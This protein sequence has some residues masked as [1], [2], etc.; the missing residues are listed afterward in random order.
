[1]EVKKRDRTEE[2]RKR[3]TKKRAA[4]K[5]KQVAAA[6]EGVESHADNKFTLIGKIKESPFYGKSSATNDEKVREILRGE[7]SVN[8]KKHIK[9]RPGQLIIFKYFTPIHKE[10]LEYYD[11]SPCTIFF[12][13]RTTSTGQK[14]VVG[15]NLHYFP[16]QIRYQVLN[17]IFEIYRPI[18]TKYFKGDD[19]EL[20]NISYKSLIEGV[21]KAKLDFGVRE[22]EVN[23][24]ADVTYIPPKYWQ[25]AVFTE[26]WFKKKTREAIM[27]YWNQFKSRL[28]GGNPNK[29]KSK[30]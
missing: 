12:G 21:K 17:K 9:I 25:L 11:A 27:K 30:K 4:T 19:R 6:L 15:F 20:S 29:P 7:L 28:V 13:T 1:M 8:K 2:Y 24:C 14:H 5:Q 16:P 26:G 22:Y 18:Y 23:L 10:E 3:N